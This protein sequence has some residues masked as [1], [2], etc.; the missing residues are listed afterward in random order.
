LYK[1][2]Q[3]LRAWYKDIDIFLISLGLTCSKEDYNLYIN[4]KANII[5]LLFVDNILLFS[6][7]KEAIYSIKVQLSTK[8]QITDLGPACQF[9]SIQIEYNC[10]ACTLQIYQKLY[11]KSI[12]KRFQ[13]ENCNRV[14]TLI[15]SNFQLAAV[16]LS[17]KATLYQKLDYQQ[18]VESIIYTILGTRPDFV[19]QISILSKFFSNPTSEY[20]LAVNRVLRYL[21]KTINTGITY[22]SI[23]NPAIKEAISYN[24]LSRQDL[25][26]R[27]KRLFGFT[28]SD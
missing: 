17:Y 14:S 21:N 27:L 1:L 12:F 16:P 7:S 6:P 15:D 24:K 2:K 23:Q 13:I 3:A 11:I 22:R 25:D 26:K 8:Y 9:L 4:I 5:L 19:F 18:G 20:V 28:D 10:Q